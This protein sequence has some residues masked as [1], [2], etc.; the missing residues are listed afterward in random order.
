MLVHPNY[1]VVYR[2]DATAIEI[3]SIIHT[4]QQYP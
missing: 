3:L 2:V 1:L 4:R